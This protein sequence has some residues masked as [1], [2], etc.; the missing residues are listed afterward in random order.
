MKAK[1]LIRIFALL[2]FLAAII[3]GMAW[4]GEPVYD[5]DKDGARC[6][7]KWGKECTLQNNCCNF[8]TKDETRSYQLGYLQGIIDGAWWANYL[9]K[10]KK[11]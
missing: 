6:L 7:P 5:P 1:T 11:K 3:A 4:G 8:F 10:G 9:I 2:L